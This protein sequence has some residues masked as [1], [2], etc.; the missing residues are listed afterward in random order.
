MHGAI[1]V[2]AGELVLEH[3]I[4]GSIELA[5][6]GLSDGLA[7]GLG[8]AFESVE[9]GV[10]VSADAVSGLMKLLDSLLDGLLVDVCRL[11]LRSTFW[12]GVIGGA[13]GAVVWGSGAFGMGSVG[14]AMLRM[15]MSGG[16][17]FVVAAGC[18]TVCRG[19]MS[20]VV[21]SA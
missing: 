7:L 12:C 4:E 1:E 14:A 16:R 2:V 17:S 8:A 13:S 3:A 10:F 15:G 18:V 21:G 6:V 20:G 5:L 19:G 11:R 9:D